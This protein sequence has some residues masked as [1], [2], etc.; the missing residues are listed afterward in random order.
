M[1]KSIKRKSYK[2]TKRRRTKKSR[3]RQ[4]QKGGKFYGQGTYG[5]VLG[6]PRIPCEDEDYEADKIREKPEISKVIFDE[7]ELEKVNKSIELIKARFKHPASLNKYIIVPSRVCNLNKE[8]MKKHAHVYTKEWSENMDLGGYD[9]Q[10]IS[11]KGKHDLNHEMSNIR[12]LD[13]VGNFAKGLIN[14]IKGLAL[15]H[16]KSIVH[17]DI[18]LGNIVAMNST[19]F[20]IIDTDEIKP[21]DKPDEINTEF[22][23]KN[24]MYVIWPIATVFTVKPDPSLTKIYNTIS[25]NITSA[26]NKGSK[27]ALETSYSV[28]F[29][30]V[31]SL[32]PKFAETMISEKD[33]NNTDVIK[34]IHALSE[35]KRL[36]PYIDRYSFG[37][38]L[39]ELLKK[40]SRLPHTTVDD[41]FGEEILNII[42][43]C[44]FVEHG[45]KTTTHEIAA[46]YEELVT[47]LF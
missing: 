4:R 25:A 13:D 14:V 21:F 27:D 24:F 18:K 22:F 34:H 42:E 30:D 23:Y 28:L 16:D 15:L 45:F 20:R 6:D 7:S 40:Y 36:Y 8:Q 1:R 43:K 39:M 46:M 19:D 29:N 47:T 32:R 12:T 44:C 5:A 3:Q 11:L 10:A 35:P 2:T 17:G 31:K 41:P 37:I 9:V 33:P 26:F 38:I